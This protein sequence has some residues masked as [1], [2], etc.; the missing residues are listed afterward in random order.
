MLGEALVAT[1]LPS[2]LIAE[3]NGFD[4]LILKRAF[5]AAELGVVVRFV[6]HGEALISYLSSGFENDVVGL[7]DRVLPAVIFL[8]L[9]MPVADGWEALRQLRADPRWTDIPVIVMSTLAHEGDIAKVYASGASGYFTKPSSFS[10]MVAAIRTSVAPWLV[11]EGAP[12][13][14]RLV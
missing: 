11:A 9:N 12:R 13:P 6:E 14:K 5:K 10:D 1:D 2:V 7:A 3:D 8:D 4:Q